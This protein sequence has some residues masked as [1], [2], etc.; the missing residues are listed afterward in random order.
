MNKEI[1]IIAA[2]VAYEITHVEAPISDLA[3]LGN[4]VGVAIQPYI[5]DEMGF[6][7]DD[8]IS[9]IKHG[10]SLGDGTH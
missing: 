4:E 3:D 1:K 9:G 7:L 6:S 5:D 10:V 2:V 8:F